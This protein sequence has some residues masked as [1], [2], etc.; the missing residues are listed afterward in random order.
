MLLGSSF[1][2]GARGGKPTASLG[3]AG[4]RAVPVPELDCAVRLYAVLTSCLVFFLSLK[5]RPFLACE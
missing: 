5:Q 1:P 3:E 2:R 4:H